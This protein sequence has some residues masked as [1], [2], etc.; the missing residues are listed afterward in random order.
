MGE[1][2]A[3]MPWRGTVLSAWV[4]GVLRE[5]GCPSVHLVGPQPSLGDHGFPVLREPPHEGH[6]PLY[7]LAAAL[8]HASGP[9]AFVVACDLPG[10]TGDEVRLLLN[11]RAPVVAQ[12][13][14][15]RLALLAALP[16]DQAGTALELAEA[17]A[18]VQSF[19]RRFPARRLADG[20]LHNANRK[21]DL[22]GW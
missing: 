17:G 22:E 14:A 13:G 7:G 8:S 10:L 20:T 16:T 5:A 6:H 15:G 11:H 4:G 1:D 2:K 18:S 9:L 12:D 3:L 19:L 21:A